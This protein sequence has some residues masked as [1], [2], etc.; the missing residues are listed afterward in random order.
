MPQGP[1]SKY[2]HI[3]GNFFNIEIWGS[4][5][6]VCGTTTCLQKV[7]VLVALWC[8]TLCSPMGCSPTGSSVHEILQ[9]KILEWVAKIQSNC[10]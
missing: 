8:P 9:A 10:L 6:I 5:D 1:T 4:P 2:P 7:K 3:G